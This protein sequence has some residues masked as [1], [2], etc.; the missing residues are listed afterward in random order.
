MERFA[1]WDTAGNERFDD[2]SMMCCKGAHAAIIVYDIT[3]ESS[4]V[5]AMCWVDKLQRVAS[6]N[7][8]KALAGNKAD[9]V[10]KREVMYEVHVICVCSCRITSGIKSAVLLPNLILS[11]HRDTISC[12]NSS[13]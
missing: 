5:K 9:R 10:S 13:S 4:F 3:R 7:I 6:P 12:G 11:H 8:F 1:I 2:I